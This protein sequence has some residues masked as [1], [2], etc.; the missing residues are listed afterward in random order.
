[1]EIKEDEF[2]RL[3]NNY[4]PEKNIFVKYSKNILT[5]ISNVIFKDKTLITLILITL[6]IYIIIILVLLIFK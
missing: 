5:I 3:K 1:M 2:V 6:L 4:D